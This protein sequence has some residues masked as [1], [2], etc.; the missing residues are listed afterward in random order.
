MSRDA[1]RHT[2]PHESMTVTV[3]VTMTV[4]VTVIIKRAWTLEHVTVNILRVN[5]ALQTDET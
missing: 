5:K 1:V 3:T 2:K 4:I